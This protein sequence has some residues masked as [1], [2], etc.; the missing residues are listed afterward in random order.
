MIDLL[1]DDFSD[2]VRIEKLSAENLPR[3][4]SSSVPEYSD[5]LLNKALLSQNAFITSTFILFENKS[6]KA[7]AF[8]SLICDSVTFTLEE[9]GDSELAEFPFSTFPAMKVAELAVSVDF[10]GKYAH[11]GSFMLKFAL[12]TAF[13]INEEHSACRFLTVDADV[14]NNPTVT[15]FYEKNGFRRLSD[16]K[17]TKKTKIVGM[18]KDILDD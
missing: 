17:Y 5:F 7:M 1:I 15:L 14:E 2:C 18:W 10:S 8:V 13:S 4:F 3:S 9:K 11:I 6:D 16:K 12:L